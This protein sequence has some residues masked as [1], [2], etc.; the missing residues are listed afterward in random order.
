M[1]TSTTAAIPV[2]KRCPVPKWDHDERGTRVSLFS[3]PY[4]R[5]T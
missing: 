5:N 4:D 3:F 2:L 1:F